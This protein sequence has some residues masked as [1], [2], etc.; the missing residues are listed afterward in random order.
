VAALRGFSIGEG[1]LAWVT[2]PGQDGEASH[3]HVL[4]WTADEFG[5][6]RSTAM[7]RPVVAR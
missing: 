3:V 6:I 5:Q 7:E 1:R 2:P 4:A